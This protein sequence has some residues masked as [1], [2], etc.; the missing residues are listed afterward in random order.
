VTSGCNSTEI[1][2]CFV[3]SNNPD[4]SNSTTT[5]TLF[6]T[7]P[8]GNFTG[9]LHC[10]EGEKTVL[11]Q[12]PFKIVYPQNFRFAGSPEAVAVT[13]CVWA[14]LTR[15]SINFTDSSGLEPSMISI[16][17]L[18]SLLGD[19]IVRNVERDWMPNN[20][21]TQQD[22]DDGNVFLNPK[23]LTIMESVRDSSFVVR[24]S[25]PSGTMVEATIRFK[26][27]YAYCPRVPSVNPIISTEVA[28]PVVLNPTSIGFHEA[29]GLSVW[30][31]VWELPSISVGRL[32]YYC[33]DF[34]CDG[35]PGW[36]SLTTSTVK[37]V[38]YFK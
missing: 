13:D 37:H 34:R 30:D 10:S 9:V 19:G 38:S 31:I 26:I 29:H 24:G 27:A 23:L 35:G 5:I 32:E 15:E 33:P 22:V 12:F 1:P 4:I 7:T 28:E 11:T 36:K 8:T 3:T 21:F 6:P 14:R 20:V 18:P 2:Q 17:Y 16:T 25:D